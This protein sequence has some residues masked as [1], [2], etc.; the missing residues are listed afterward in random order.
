MEAID[1]L[2]EAMPPPAKDIQLNLSSVLQG[3]ALSDDQRWGVAV[4]SAAVAGS[5]A[6]YEAMLADAGARVGEAVLDDA[7]AAA[8]LMAMNNVFYR[9]RHMV[10]KETYRAKPARLRMNRIAQPKTSKATFELMCL[11]VSAIAATSRPSSK[12][13]SPKT[14]STTP[15]ASPPSSVR[16]RWRRGS[17][18]RAPRRATPHEE[19]SRRGQRLSW[20]GSGS[21]AASTGNIGRPRGMPRGR[22]FRY[23]GRFRR[24]EPAEHVRQ[25]PLDRI[26]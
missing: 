4:A 3:G 15:F 19:R 10:G 5:P 13:G 17:E 20:C 21:A 1:R 26:A 25:V 22:S 18:P 12:A 6:L 16:R 7:R 8:A 24:K 9:F 11:A 2:R 14:T 23:C